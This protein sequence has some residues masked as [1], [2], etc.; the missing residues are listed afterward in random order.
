MAKRKAAG[1]K[2]AVR[3][4]KEMPSDFGAFYPTGYVV[5]AFP[6]P[7]GAKRVRKDLLTG[8]YDERDVIHFDAAAM[9]RVLANSLENAGFLASLG[10]TKQT[11]RKQ[12]GFAEKGCDFL[13]VHAPTDDEAERVMRVA[14]R[15]PLR[16][17][18][19]FHRFAIEDLK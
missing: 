11:L 19:K 4:T 9:S 16:L 3:K 15:L 17:A 10:T 18:Q 6:K 13:L 8:G 2:A 14:R 5:L 12:L 1:S 7:A